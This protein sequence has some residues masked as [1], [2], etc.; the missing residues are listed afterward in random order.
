MN[1]WKQELKMFDSAMAEQRRS[2]TDKPSKVAVK[3]VPRYMTATRNRIALRTTTVKPQ[4][5]LPIMRF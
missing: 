1:K 4:K 2:V 3:K 5:R